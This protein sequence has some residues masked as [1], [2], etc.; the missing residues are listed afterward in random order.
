MS[1]VATPLLEVSVAQ[2]GTGSP[3][4]YLH[5]VLFD[6]VTPEGDVPQVIDLLSGSHTVYAPAL[7]GFRDLKELA[8]VETVEDYVFLLTDVLAA[9]SLDRPHVVGTG[10]GGWIAAELAVWQPDALGTLTLVNAFGLRVEDHPTAR[11]FDAAAP[12]P[13]GGRREVRQILFAEPNGELALGVLPDFPEDDAN[14][15][16]FTN[17]HAAARIGW[18][19]PAFYDARLGSRLN[20]V[21]VPTH[22]VWGAADILV[23][24]EHGRAYEAGIAGASLTVIEGAGHAI[25]VEK[26]DDLAKA[27]ASFIDQHDA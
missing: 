17:V 12:N 27:I 19:P 6:L 10:F 1:L 11:F 23:D 25:T 5:D 26:P 3:V 22:I 8:A 21:R 24:V 20:R 18:A 15:R 7:P 16:F 9:L 2:L 13:L 14:E 4:V